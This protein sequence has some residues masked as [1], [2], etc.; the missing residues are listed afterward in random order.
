[1]RCPPSLLGSSL[2]DPRHNTAI[3]LVGAAVAMLGMAYAS[4]PLYRMF[5][6]KTGFGGTTQVAKSFPDHVE[7]RVIKVRF[8]ADVNPSLPWS[9]K[10]L[11]TSVDVKVGEVGLAFYEGT[12]ESSEPTVGMATYNVTPAKAGIY[13]NK[14]EC[15]C[16]I[17]QHMEPNQT[18]S[19]PVEFFIDPDIMNDPNCDDIETITLSYTF[20]KL[21]AGK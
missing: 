21:P 18:S 19:F 9:F 12:N 20:F 7:D 15:F 14:V 6:Q 16:F 8:N 13:F 2:K 5:C 3:I 10:T 4:V 17:E 1:M 11:Q